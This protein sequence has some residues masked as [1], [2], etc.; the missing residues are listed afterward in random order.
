M[1]LKEGVFILFSYGIGAIPTGYLIARYHKGIDIRKHGSGN[2]GA[3]N[4]T[5]MLG[6]KWGALVLVLDLTKS[7][8]VVFGA[9]QMGFSP[10]VIAEAAYSTFLGNCFSV[11][12]KGA[13]G[14]G[15]ATSLGIY[16]AL[17]PKVF[18]IG[19]ICYL[20][21]RG[22]TQ[23]SAIGSLAASLVIPAFGYIW[24]IPP[25]FYLTLAISALVIVRHQANVRQVY[26][27]IF[28]K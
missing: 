1:I 20:L 9:H 21:L 18:F 7:F 23:I 4:V 8:F 22:L 26:E 13:G 25:Y 10:I 24:M 17:S 28:R 19:V 16:L 12:L 27:K 5:R 11:F 15:V 6:K 3:T 2:M 14:K